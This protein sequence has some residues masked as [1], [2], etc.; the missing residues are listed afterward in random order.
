MDDFFSAELYIAF[1]ANR[2]FVTEKEFRS[3]FW[4]EGKVA[5]PSIG[6]SLKLLLVSLDEN[7]SASF[8]CIDVS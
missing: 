7:S 6:S 5:I 2:D 1:L 3:Y 8:R 4:A